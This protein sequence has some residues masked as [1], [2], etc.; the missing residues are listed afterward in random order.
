MTGLLFLLLFILIKNAAKDGN[1]DA[2]ISPP[3]IKHQKFQNNWKDELEAQID[4]PSNISYIMDHGI[5][6]YHTHEYCYISYLLTERQEEVNSTALF[7]N[8]PIK[9]SEFTSVPPQILVAARYY[10]ADRYKYCGFL[11]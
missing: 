4:Q 7:S 5:S 3:I 1:A 8:Y 6:K 2:V 10:L 9:Y 11:N